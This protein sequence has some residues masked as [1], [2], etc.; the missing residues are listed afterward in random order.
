MR[1]IITTIIISLL[2]SKGALSQDP[3]TVER[4]KNDR[5]QRRESAVGNIID[6][7]E[8]ALFVR[9]DQQERRIEYYEKYNN[10]KEV[11]KVKE[12]ALKE[13]RAIIDAFKAYYKFSK[14]YFMAMEDSQFLLEGKMSHIRFYNDSGKID[15]SIIPQPSNIFVADFSFIEQDTTIFFSSYTPTPNNPDNPRGETYYGGSKTSKPA[16]VVRN[17]KFQQLRD[18][19]PFYTGFSPFGRVSKKFR[20]PVKKLN[21]QLENFYSKK[22]KGESE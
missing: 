21:E 13:N 6:L 2:V 3:A 16:L 18:P 19:F 10:D 11:K 5:D 22:S 1:R 9:L 14:V 7:K 15:P 20:L 12:K 8:G 17:D 4:L